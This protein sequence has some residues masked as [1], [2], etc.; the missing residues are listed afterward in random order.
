MARSFLT[1]AALSCL[2]PP[3]RGPLNVRIAH[4]SGDVAATAAAAAAAQSAAAAA[5][6]D[7]DQA[8]SDAAAAQST[9]DDAATAASDIGASIDATGVAMGYAPTSVTGTGFA[10]AAVVSVPGSITLTNGRRYGVEGRVYARK[11]DGTLL[12]VKKVEGVEYLRSGG[13]FSLVAEGDE[14]L[15][16]NA[17]ADIGTYFT[18]ENRRPGLGFDGANLT[19]DWQAENGQSFILEADLAISDLGVATV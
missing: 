14:R 15:L 7:A 11:A 2:V 4:R 5:Q 9:A 10:D 18:A 16:A 13:N 17:H 8:I 19:L 12:M 3:V 1:L 6:A